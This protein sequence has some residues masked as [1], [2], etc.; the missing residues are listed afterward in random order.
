VSLLEKEH[1]VTVDTTKELNPVDTPSGQITFEQDPA[2][3]FLV[4]KSSLSAD[5]DRQGPAPYSGHI[6]VRAWDQAGKLMETT[7]SFAPGIISRTVVRRPKL[8]FHGQRR[9]CR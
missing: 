5:R 8:S 9:P 3:R 6:A 2:R 7:E 4:H 1:I